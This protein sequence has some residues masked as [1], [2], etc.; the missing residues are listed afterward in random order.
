MEQPF[1]QQASVQDASDFL[2]QHNN[3]LFSFVSELM[4]VDI[5]LYADD[6][7]LIANDPVALQTMLNR[8]H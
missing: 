3:K 6:L 1:L 2:L 7:T 4:P 8:L 5:M